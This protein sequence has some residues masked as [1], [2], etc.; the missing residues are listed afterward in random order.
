MLSYRKVS[1]GYVVMSIMLVNNKVQTTT[2]EFPHTRMGEYSHARFV[3]ENRDMENRTRKRGTR[4]VKK[5]DSDVAR[6]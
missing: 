3:E 4:V 6:A 2:K 1:N 5:S